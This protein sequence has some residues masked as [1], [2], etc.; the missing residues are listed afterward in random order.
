MITYLIPRLSCIALFIFSISSMADDIDLYFSESININ[1]EKPNILFVIDTSGSM[2]KAA[3][4]T[5]TSQYHP[6]FK[7]AN[8]DEYGRFSRNEYWYVIS[9]WHNYA[10]QYKKI[11]SI[12][13]AAILDTLKRT[14]IYSGPA[15]IDNNGYVTCAPGGSTTQ[16]TIAL[17]NYLNWQNVGHTTRGNRTRMDVVQEAFKNLL[18]TLKNVNIGIMRFDEG[19]NGSMGKHGG[20]VVLAIQPIEDIR[21]QA[22]NIVND[23][24]PTAWTPITETVDEARRYFEGAAPLY[25]AGLYANTKTSSSVAES[26]STDKSHYISPI[27]SACQ[28]NHL[29]LFTD[30]EPREDKDSNTT[31][32]TL[33]Y[34]LKNLHPELPVIDGVGACDGTNGSCLDELTYYLRHTDIR[35]D[36]NGPQYVISH[37]IGGFLGPTETGFLQRAANAG[38]GNY[39]SANNPLELSNALT[40]IIDNII[41]LDS[42]FTAPAV[43]ASAGNRLTHDNSM[44]FALFRPLNKTRWPGNLKKYRLNNDGILYGKNN[45]PA[46]DNQ[47]GLFASQT[48]DYWNNSDQPDGPKTELGGAANVIISQVQRQIFFNQTDDSMASLTSDTTIP[49]EL[50]QDPNQSKNLLQWVLGFD[51]N[52][53]NGNNSTTD[54]RY[55]I[56]DPLHSEPRIVNYNNAT[57]LIFFGSNEGYLHA[58]D[59]KTGEEVYG[60]LPRELMPNQI[61]YF[62]DVAGYKNKPYGLDGQISLLNDDGNKSLY[63]GMRR[64]GRNYYALDITTRTSPAMKFVI[65]GGE[66]DFAKLGQSWAK[67]I[68]AKIKYNGSITQVLIITGGYDPLNENNKDWAADNMGNAIY[69]A[70]AHTGKRLWWASDSGANANHP[71]MLNSMPASAALVDINGDGLLDYFYASDTGGHIFRIDINKINSGASDLATVSLFASLGGDTLYGGLAGADNNRRFFTSPSVSFWPDSSNGDFL[72]LAIGSGLREVPRSTDIQ[73]IFYVLRDKNPYPAAEKPAEVLRLQHQNIAY[74]DEHFVNI[75]LETNQLDQPYYADPKNA[76]EKQTLITRLKKADAWYFPLAKAQGEKVVSDAIT[77]DGSVFFSSFANNNTPQ[78]S[79][80]V[81][82][83]RSQFYALDL[84]LGSATLD[85]DGDGLITLNDLKKDL[86]NAGFAPR[87]VVIFRENNRKTIMPGTET[88]EDTRYDDKENDDGRGPGSGDRQQNTVQ[89]LYWREKM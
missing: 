61:T 74:G 53:S 57:G 36:L 19:N 3:P 70:D 40:Q 73:D 44:Y 37:M 81:S 78:D 39:V 72:S 9:A 7:Y 25:G 29:V 4:E 10:N 64:G 31:I 43:T 63:V 14:Y 13:C 33:Y 52:D 24:T 41:S 32:N 51:S 65:H 62:N 58:I 42:T 17:G 56:A 85:L 55:P 86:N 2:D 21:E 8:V 30:G 47:T 67:A 84:L 45:A 71:A 48:Q 5:T 79:C 26:L 50:S 69:I 22:I 80:G 82:L 77:F 66:G 1:N 16:Y 18:T 83:G 6:E 11:A 87:P 23:L 46:I 89:K 49:A 59:S 75:G 54:N 15:E 88:I 27:T 35:P 20:A 38:E 34:Q 12:N 28:K 60:F 68:P 76:K